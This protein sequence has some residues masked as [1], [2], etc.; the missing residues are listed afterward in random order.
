MDARYLV[1]RGDVWVMSYLGRLSRDCGAS[2]SYIF[3]RNSSSMPSRV[4]T[5][6]PELLFARTPGNEPSMVFAT[7]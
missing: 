7:R 4:I 6:Y 5:M 2:N 3:W 1:W